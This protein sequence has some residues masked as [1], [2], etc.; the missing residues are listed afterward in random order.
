L[1]DF[2]GSFGEWSEVLPVIKPGETVQ[3]ELEFDG[4]AG[5]LQERGQSIEKV[6]AAGGGGHY[7]SGFGG[8]GRGECLALRRSG[9]RHLA[10][11]IGAD[12]G[13]EMLGR[14]SYVFGG[15]ELA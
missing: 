12:A 4:I 1:Q 3:D 10:R 11:Q 6:L 14:A 2:S 7:G 8:C 5:I 15:A 13:L 9:G